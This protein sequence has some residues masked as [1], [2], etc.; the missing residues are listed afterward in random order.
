[1]NESCNP[2]SFSS[3]RESQPRR[4]NLKAALLDAVQNV[5][6][7][8]AAVG[9]VVVRTAA[10]A[11]EIIS[12]RELRKKSL[13]FILSEA[14]TRI[15]TIN[16]GLQNRIEEGMRHNR[17]QLQDVLSN[18]EGQINNYRRTRA[19]KLF[20]NELVDVQCGSR[21]W[22]D[23][24]QEVRTRLWTAL[25]SR[26]DLPLFL[27]GP[28]GGILASIDEEHEKDPSSQQ[29][30]KSGSYYRST[31]ERTASEEGEGGEEREG[32]HGEEEKE[33]EVEEDEEEE[34]GER[35]AKYTGYENETN[36][37]LPKYKERE[38]RERDED[39]DEEGEL[40]TSSSG[41]SRSICSDAEGG[42]LQHGEEEEEEKEE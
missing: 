32:R 10:S 6:K 26:P 28:I 13:N 17:R 19:L 12:D 3:E 25:A 11:Q 35:L 5:S 27:L 38:R 42:R 33:T 41:E 1:M 2:A 31:K 20:R 40:G 37:L 39:E 16:T 4:W 21:L 9:E 7:V 23:V 34:E 30:D 22:M 18:L 29:K 8:T 14:Q 36:E 24:P 15:H